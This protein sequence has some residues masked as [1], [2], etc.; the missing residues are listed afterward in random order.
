MLRLEKELR[1]YAIRAR[2]GEIGKVHA[3][4]FDDLSWTVRYLVANTGNWL[5]QRL[6]LI[7]PAALR[8]PDWTDRALPVALSMAQVERSPDIDLDKPV[9]RQME[10]EL[11]QY[12]SWPV[13]WPETGVGFV[14]APIAASPEAEKKDSGDEEEEKGDPHLRSTREISGYHI[15]ARDGEIGHVEDFVVDDGNWSIRYVVVDT[16][17]ILPGKQVL[18][19]PAWIE[20]VKWDGAEVHVDL[21]RKRVQN[22]P[23]F[24]PDAPVNR[25]FEERL[26]DFYGRPKYWI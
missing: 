18:V 14:G 3:F 26:Y 7:S 16:K 4:L 19:A 22:S 17:N 15:H 1:G 9:S 13:Y 25:E 2:D 12:Y 23:E 24:V 5:D 6:V 21:M 20:K 11:H 10:I 8:Q